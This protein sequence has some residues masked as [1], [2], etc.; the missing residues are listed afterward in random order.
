MRIPNWREPIGL[1][2]RPD[3]FNWG[4]GPAFGAIVGFFVAIFVSHRAF[5][6]D[7]DEWR[8]PLVWLVYW[9][10]IIAV[11]WRHFDRPEDPK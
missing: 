3:I 6:I 11:G 9:V 2:D 1:R 7:L 4:W 8:F 5:G 10:P